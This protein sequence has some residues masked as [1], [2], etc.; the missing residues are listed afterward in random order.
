MRDRRHGR[1]RTRNAVDL[2]R[3][4]PRCGSA[5]PCGPGEVRRSCRNASSGAAAGDRHRDRDRARSSALDPAHSVAV[6]RLRRRAPALRVQAG[7]GEA[8]PLGDLEHDRGSRQRPNRADSGNRTRLAGPRRIKWGRGC[9][10]SAPLSGRYSNWSAAR[11]LTLPARP[12]RQ[13]SRRDV[14]RRRDGEDDRNRAYRD[15][16][17]QSIG[18]ETCLRLRQDVPPDIYRRSVPPRPRG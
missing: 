10:T 12:G 8:P 3:M 14:D 11:T 13:K 6:Q 2:G 7:L 9:G 4:G 15:R 17:R 5:G 16:Q 18:A 1:Q